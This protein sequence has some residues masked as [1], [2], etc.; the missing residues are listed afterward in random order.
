MPS[1]TSTPNSTTGRGGKPLN[2]DW[3]HTEITDALKSRG[4]WSSKQKAIMRR[5]L[6]ERPKQK[7][8]PYPGAPNF[9][10][11]VIDDNVRERTEKDLMLLFNAPVLAHAIPLTPVDTK[12][13]TTIQIAFDSYLR[14]IIRIRAKIESALDTKNS[15]GI[16][17]IKQIRK[18]NRFL[19]RVVPDIE[20][21]DNLSLIVPIDTELVEEA[22]WVAHVEKFTPR[23][24]RKE[25]VARGWDLNIVNKVIDHCA[26]NSGN[27]GLNEK[28][29]FEE[30]KDLFGVSNSNSDK[31]VPVVTVYHHASDLEAGKGE[32]I[33]ED[34]RM[35]TVYCPTAPFQDEYILTRYAW[36]EIDTVEALSPD[37]IKQE[38]VQASTEDR[39]PSAE[40]VVYGEDRDWPFAQLRYEER[41]NYFYDSRGIGELVMDDQIEA[42][43]SKNSEAVLRE[44]Y[45]KPML[46]GDPQNSSNFS[47]VPGSVMPKGVKFAD[48][49]NVPAQLA[50]DQN[51]TRFNASRR[52]GN[53]DQHNFSVDVGR[54][55]LERTATEI[56]DTRSSS[57]A[58]TN[59]SVDRSNEGMMFVFQLLWDDMYR[60]SLE[61]PI[62]GPR[63]DQNS[64]MAPKD[65]LYTANIM[66]VPASTAKHLDPEV[67][68]GRMQQIISST[69][70]LAQVLNVPFDGYEALSSLLSNYDANLTYGWI[71]SP[72]Q[73]DAGGMPLT[74]KIDQM[75]EAITQLAQTG[76]A[77]VDEIEQLEK[78][79]MELVQRLEQTEQG[80]VDDN[81]STV[82]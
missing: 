31:R 12:I 20:I 8:H 53:A 37:E 78:Q 69:A 59:A 35:V 54:R 82:G 55:N 63:A 62:I 41:V 51:R 70:D 9:V 68:V 72:E 45:Q 80:L 23:K 3:I 43:H 34:G 71:P 14:Y 27:T 26:T 11:P 46:E 48:M 56:Q 44:Y 2:V 66:M 75:N 10:D 21:I 32:G 7:Q 39:E 42:T 36:K 64:Q 19:K 25:A 30:T 13:R 22:E 57:N 74:S 29:R 52:V 79:L 4:T 33:V 58:T 67:Q 60:M 1:D 38:K 50:F 5:R 24:M 16:S 47:F 61:F 65:A 49:P 17:T 81:L 76:E 73:I 28:S 15:Q 40:R 18:Y 6:C 77:T